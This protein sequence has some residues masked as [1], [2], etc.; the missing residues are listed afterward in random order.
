MRLFPPH[1]QSW[2]QIQVQNP[3][4]PQPLPLL[5][6]LLT[7]FLPFPPLFHLPFYILPSPI[8]HPFPIFLPIRHSSFSPLLFLLSPHPFVVCLLLGIANHLLP[9]PQVA[10]SPALLIYAMVSRRSPGRDLPLPLILPYLFLLIT[11]LLYTHSLIPTPHHH[12][13]HHHPLSIHY[14]LI[15]IHHHPSHLPHPIHHQSIHPSPHHSITPHSP[16]ITSTIAPVIVLLLNLSFLV[17]CDVFITY[18]IFYIL[19][20]S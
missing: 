14:P 10:F 7:L 20:T 4:L 2:K 19:S 1:L 18:N 5:S 8:P 17:I 3:S 13:H 16:H 9:L 12:H 15:L 11:S 6:T